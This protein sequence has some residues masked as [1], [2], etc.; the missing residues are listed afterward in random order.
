MHIQSFGDRG[1]IYLAQQNG[2]KISQTINESSPSVFNIAALF[3]K[4]L[5]YNIDSTVVNTKNALSASSETVYLFKPND[6]SI[7]P[8]Y[9]V[10]TPVSA[11]KESWK[12]L[13]EASADIYQGA[14]DRQVASVKAAERA[15]KRDKEGAVH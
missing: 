8:E 4:G 1:A 6:K 14:A 10:I 9:V 13:T 7:A 2:V 5:L 3:E 15:E 11:L 12:S